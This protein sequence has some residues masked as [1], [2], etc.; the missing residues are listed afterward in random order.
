MYFIWVDKLY[1]YGGSSSSSVVCFS[2][3]QDMS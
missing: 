3:Y 1:Y 2:V